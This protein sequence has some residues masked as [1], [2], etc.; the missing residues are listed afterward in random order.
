MNG[1]KA[2][3]TEYKGYR[4]R[5]RLEA[6]WAIFFDTCSINWEYESEGI[7]LSDGTY[8]LPDFY[9]PTFKCFFEVK[10]KGIINTPEEE[11]A[12]WKISNGQHC[13]KWAGIIAYGDPMDDILEIFCRKIDDKGVGDYSEPV[14]IGFYPGTHEPY[15]LSYLDFKP[16]K[17][18]TKLGKNK[19][20]IP[21]VTL[22]EDYEE[23]VTHRITDPALE[24]YEILEEL[25]YWDYVQNKQIQRYN[26][27]VTEDIW[28]ARKKAR[29]TRFE[30][31][32]A[33]RI[34]RRSL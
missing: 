17:F 3:E 23:Y 20:K 11:K 27:F 9:L 4:F 25:G 7:I 24:R 26:A 12:I 1:L 33:P 31:G 21:M 29:Q 32:E 8:Y 34:R 22:E 14:T 10:H 13:S 2:I 18:Y 15:L 30:Y 6:R 5:S 19:D 28:Y 16:A